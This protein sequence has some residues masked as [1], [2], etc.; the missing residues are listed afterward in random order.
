MI[1]ALDTETTGLDTFHGCLPFFVTICTDEQLKKQESPYYWEWDVDPLTRRPIIPE[2]DIERILELVRSADKVILQNAKFDILALNEVD[3]RFYEEW[4]WDKTYDTMYAGHTIS[5]IENRGLGDM[6]LNY[7]GID[8]TEYENNLH[9]VIKDVIKEINKSDYLELQTWKLAKVGMKGLPSQDNKAWACDY[10]LPKAYAKYTE[11]PSDHIYNTCLRE[12]ALVDS[13]VTLSL[14]FEQEKILKHLGRYAQFERRMKVLRIAA[15][16]ELRGVTTNSERHSEIETRYTK[17][18]IDMGERCSAIAENTYKHRLQFPKGSAVNNNLRELLLNKMKL[19]PI[20][21]EKA[22][23]AS[24]TLNKD[25]LNI[26]LE[27]SEDNTEQKDFISNLLTKRKKDKTLSD[28]ET[29]TRFRKLVK[30]STYRLHPNL[31]P[32]GPKTLRWSCSNP[33]EQNISKGEQYCVRCLGDGE[34]LGDECPLCKGSGV[35]PYSVRYIL[36][37]AEGREWWSLDAKN[38]ELRIPFYLSGDKT[39][40]DLF[41]RPD[42]PPY[43]GSYHFAIFDLLHPEKYKEHG[44]KVKKLSVYGSTWYQWVKNGNFAVQYGAG[45][46]TAD[47]A[48]HVPGARK[49]IKERFSKL[50]A[51]NQSKI[52]EADRNGFIKTQYGYPLALTRNEF[53]TISPTLPLSYFVQGTAMDWEERGMIR[54]FDQLNKWRAEDDF[55]AFITMQVHDECVFDMPYKPD[56]GNLPRVRKLASLFE[57]AGQEIGIPIPV[58]IEYHRVHWGEGVTVS[59]V[60]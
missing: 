50:E 11:L 55:D 3:N 34:F 57:I 12:Y 45:D 49:R 14:W 58:G 56:M 59:S 21:N 35:D 42:D 53:S 31:H 38:I 4:D 48:F 9:A 37:P 1:I 7:L 24:P 19:R 46:R 51:L 28:L 2:G 47:K 30:G 36:G 5:S 60:V 25:A 40:T 18:S 32:T 43:F 44:V 29:Y 17:E 54:C 20:Y 33:N 8:I 6:A 39:L 15:D 41:E 23:T 22:K 26:Y 10:W 52:C 16:M 13:M 27:E